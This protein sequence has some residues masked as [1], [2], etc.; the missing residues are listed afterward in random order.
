MMI[1][2]CWITFPSTNDHKKHKH[3]CTLNPFLSGWVFLKMN[4][5]QSE[6][7]PLPSANLIFA[8]LFGLKI[9]KISEKS[10]NIEW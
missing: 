4:F 10:E 2:A 5:I 3:T 6:T 9:I 1:G 7:N 8:R